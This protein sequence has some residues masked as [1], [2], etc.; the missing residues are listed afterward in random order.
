MFYTYIIYS[1]RLERYY[2]GSTNNLQRRLEDHNRGKDKYTRKGFPW[3]LKYSETFP[4][5]AEAYSREFEIKLKKSRSYIEQL[6]LSQK[7]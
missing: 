5:R 4:S 3:E 2:V 1:P 6:I 7:H